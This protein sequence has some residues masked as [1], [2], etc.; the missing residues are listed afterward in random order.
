MP[1]FKVKIRNN[2]LSFVLRTKQYLLKSFSY[3]LQDCI[4][5]IDDVHVKASIPPEDQVPYIGR[6]GIP[7]QNI[8]VACNIDMQFIFACAGWEGTAHNTRVFL[9]ALRNYALNFPKH[10]NG[11]V[12]NMCISLNFEFLHFQ[13][14]L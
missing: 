14:I 8:M 11:N 3:C 9:S 13:I 10:P 7:T 5:A 12:S 6:Q 1:H 2:N 4:G